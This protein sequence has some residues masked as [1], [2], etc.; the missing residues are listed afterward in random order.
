MMLNRVPQDKLLSNKRL[1]K[2]EEHSI[3]HKNAGGHPLK[4][5]FQDGT[6]YGADVLVACDGIKSVIRQSV[7]GDTLPCQKLKPRF[8]GTTVYRGLCPMDDALTKIGDKARQSTSKSLA[9]FR[10]G[11]SLLR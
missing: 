1:V 7:F 10:R 11:P 6:E 4:L 9:L 3:S 2:Y 8:T 5:T